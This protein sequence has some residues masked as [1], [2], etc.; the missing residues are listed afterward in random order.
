MDFGA[1]YCNFECTV[2]TEICPSGA[3]RKMTVEEKKLNQAGRVVF[4][5]QNC[6]VYTENTDCGACTEHCPTKA[7]TMVPYKNSRLPEV[8]PEYCIGCGAC[9]HACPT[10]PYR[11][12]YVDGN[13]VHL[14]A[15]KKEPEKKQEVNLK[16]DFPF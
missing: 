10:R 12:I 4:I 11:A 2:C 9:E 6:V 14:I 13:P 7:V 3:M 16:D 5:K 15:K 1:S 8:K